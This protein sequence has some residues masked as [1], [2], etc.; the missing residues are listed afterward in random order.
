M[1]CVLR[2][3]YLYDMSLRKV[4]WQR[5][6]LTGVSPTNF[7]CRW[8]VLKCR[9]AELK[10]LNV[11]PHRRHLPP[12]PPSNKRMTSWLKVSS[13]RTA[14]SGWGSINGRTDPRTPPVE[15][16]SA[17]S[18]LCLKITEK[19]SPTLRANF[20]MPKM[21]KLVSFWKTEAYGQTVLP[22]RSVSI[23]QEIGVKFW[24]IF[25]HYKAAADF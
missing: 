14:E 18:T 17:T 21:I 24:M 9:R 2:R 11:R 12:P 20:F 7:P 8:T 5:S 10:R 16:P 1:V 13:P 4:L 23:G 6:H 19:V 25:K 3:W 22:Y 15:T